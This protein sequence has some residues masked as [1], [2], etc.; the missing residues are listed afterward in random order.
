MVRAV[1]DNVLIRAVS[2][3]DIA[4]KGP[5]QSP[6][7]VRDFPSIYHLQPHHLHSHI[8]LNSF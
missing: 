1:E 7:E 5:K 2:Y 6:E 8:L 3:A 4:A